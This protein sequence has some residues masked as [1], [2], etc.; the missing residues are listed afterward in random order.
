MVEINN[1]KIQSIK[2]NGRQSKLGSLGNK[3]I[4]IYIRNY[5]RK[6]L[7]MH[8]EGQEKPSRVINGDLELINYKAEKEESV[9]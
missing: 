6:N 1:N 4:N 2:I 3:A 8:S 9:N 7:K 5:K